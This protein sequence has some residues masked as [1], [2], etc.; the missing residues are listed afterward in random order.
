MDESRSLN[1]TRWLIWSTMYYSA[2]GCW[3][4]K[5]QWPKRSENTAPSDDT[6]P[7]HVRD[8]VRANF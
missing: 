6:K 5:D 1:E 4:T 8:A 3:P 2:T 7:N